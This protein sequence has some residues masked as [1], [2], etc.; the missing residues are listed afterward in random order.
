MFCHDDPLAQLGSQE[1]GGQSVYVNSLVKELDKKGWSVDVYTRLDSH[2][3]NTLSLMGKR[4]RLIRL[5]GGPPRYVSRKLLFDFLPQIYENFLSYINHQNPYS[6]FHGHYWDG[7]LLALKA[8]EQFSVPFVENFHSLGKLRLQAKEEYSVDVNEKDL[9]DQRFSVENEIIKKA[10]LIISLSDSEKIFLG[11]KYNVF[12]ERVRVIPGG[13]DLKIFHPRPRAES[14]Q[15]LSIEDDSFVLLFVGRL[16]WRKGIG[17]LIHAASL[18]KESIPT[19]KALIIGGKIYGRQKN[20]DDFKEYQR[21]M[22]IAEDLGVKDRINFLGCI[23]HNRLPLF[24][25]ASDI[26]VIP[27]YYEPFGLVALESMACNAPVIVSAVGGL[28][29]IIQDKINGLLVKPRNPQDLK[30]KVLQIYNSKEMAE[31]LI[32]NA[33][34]NVVDNYSWK[35]IAE[36]I[37]EIYKKLIEENNNASN[38]NSLS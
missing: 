26:F 38:E 14:R 33:H 17:T 3:K 18:L 13:V 37:C 30:E 5:V 7:G 36:K 32:K 24:Y 12:S 19:L 35:S 11:E 8:H 23:G 2:H 21:L 4:S 27:S 31:G 20:V 10:N 15:K 34:K 16:E 1:S 28:T 6:L 9:F 25:S 22:K 29:N